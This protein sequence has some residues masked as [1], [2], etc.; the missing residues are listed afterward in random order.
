MGRILF[1][2]IFLLVMVGCTQPTLNKVQQTVKREASLLVD[3]GLIVNKYVLLYPCQLSNCLYQYFQGN[4]I[5]SSALHGQLST[6]THTH[7]HIVHNLER[8]KINVESDI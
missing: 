4:L 8:H 3:S 5:A 1:S 7:T 2:S 6:H